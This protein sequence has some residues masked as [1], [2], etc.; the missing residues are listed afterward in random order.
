ML[1]IRNKKLWF[2]LLVPV[3]TLLV[4]IAVL[5]SDFVEIY[6]SYLIIPMVFRVLS[7]MTGLL[8]FSLAE[9]VLLLLLPVIL[10]MICVFIVKLVKSRNKKQYIKDTVINILVCISVVYSVF[11]LS[12]GIYY[13]RPSI[14]VYLGYTSDDM[15]EADEEELYNICIQLINECNEL[16]EQ[17]DDEKYLDFEYIAKETEKAYYKLGEKLPIFKGKYGKPKRVLLSEYM[18]YTEIVGIFFPF[19][20]E[21][22][23]NDQVVGY[24]IPFNACHEMAHMYGFMKEDEANFIAYLACMASDKAEIKYSGVMQALLMCKNDLYYCDNESWNKADELINKNVALDYHNNNLYWEKIE[25]D[26]AGKV[27]SDISEQV[28]NTYL[29]VNGQADGVKSYNRMVKLII[30]LFRHE[31]DRK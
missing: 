19:T 28:N 14:A 7:L 20:M 13:Y 30:A 25:N 18:S 6:R 16:S 17:I 22:N 9:I 1:N 4:L 5:F 8:P 10:M 27:V 12:C 31:Y 15:A 3:S 29:K 2:L 23:V 21:A 24:T 11:I 26:S